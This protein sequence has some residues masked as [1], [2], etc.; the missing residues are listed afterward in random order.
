MCG[1][2]GVFLG[3]FLDFFFGEVFGF[4]ASIFLLRVEVGGC[5]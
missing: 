2:E 1:S 3:G 4:V 5:G